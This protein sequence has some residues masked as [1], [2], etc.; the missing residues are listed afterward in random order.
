[1]LALKRVVVR[2]AKLFDGHKPRCTRRRGVGNQRR[3]PLR[4]GE[5]TFGRRTMLVG[6]MLRR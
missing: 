2:Y 4:D 1:M 5:Y 6:R 3:C